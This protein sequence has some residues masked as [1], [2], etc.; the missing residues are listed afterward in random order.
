MEEALAEDNTKKEGIK[1]KTDSIYS[2]IHS[3]FVEENDEDTEYQWTV[4][5]YA[6][7]LDNLGLIGKSAGQNRTTWAAEILHL[8]AGD[9]FPSQ[10]DID[11][12]VALLRK[13]FADQIKEEQ[14]GNT[15]QD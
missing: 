9:V 4:D 5:F 14:D 6:K 12:S 11:E 7:C 13:R 2:F 8:R 3:Q 10:E 1:N 15:G